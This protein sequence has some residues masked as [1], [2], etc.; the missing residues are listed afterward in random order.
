MKTVGG[1]LVVLM[2]EYEITETE[3]GS[4]KIKWVAINDDGH[5]IE[6][7]ITQKI[8]QS[9]VLSDQALEQ[10]AQELVGTTINDKQIDI[11]DDDVQRGMEASSIS[12]Q[13]E[14][15]YFDE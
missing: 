14:E 1:Y 11:Y 8:G 13:V 15:G 2:S 9:T 7:Q 3:L 4:N 5:Q 6:G 12:R 10:M